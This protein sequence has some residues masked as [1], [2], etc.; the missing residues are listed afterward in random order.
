MKATLDEL[1]DQWCFQLEKGETHGKLH[2]QCRVLMKKEGRKPQYG[3]TML[4]MFTCRKP[5]EEKDL[6]FQIESNNSVQQGALAFYVMK[7]ESRQAG[8]WYDS[9]YKLPKPRKVYEGKDLKVVTLKT[10]WRVDDMIR[11]EEGT[12]QSQFAKQ[13]FKQVSR[14]ITLLRSQKSEPHRHTPGGQDPSEVHPVRR[15]RGLLRLSLSR[16]VH[17]PSGP[18]PSG[19]AGLSRRRQPITHVSTRDVAMATQLVVVVLVVVLLLTEALVLDLRRLR[20]LRRRVVAPIAP[21]PL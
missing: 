12:E 16:F 9:T 7:D 5:Y 20:P 21:V 3:A 4:Q 14:K 1:T 17:R 8:P 11:G 18:M 2:Y 19:S 6:S 13:Q 10:F 15:R